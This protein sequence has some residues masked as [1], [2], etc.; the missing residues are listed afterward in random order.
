[1][2][3]SNIVDPDVEI[4]VGMD[5]LALDINVGIPCGLIVNE[6]ASNSL[7]YAFPEGRTGEIRLGLSKNTDGNHV[8][9]VGDNGRGF[10]SELDFRHTTSLGLQL[11]NVL[12]RQIHGSIEL[13]TMVVRK[14]W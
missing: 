1:M 10:P 8:L 4:V 2:P 9:T 6:L 13:E 3:I 11:V 5:A 7:K 14:L 12:T